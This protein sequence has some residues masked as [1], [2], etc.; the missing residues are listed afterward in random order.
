MNALRSRRPP[1][2]DASPGDEPAA[3]ATPAESLDAA[4]EAALRLLENRRRTRSDL[5]KRLRDKGHAAADVEAA[6]DRLAGVGL[7][8]DVEY[9]RAF[10]A[11][12]WGRRASGWRRL[13]ME[14][15]RR[16]VAPDDIEKARAGFE[17]ERG[18]ADEVAM[19]RRVIAQSERRYAALEPRVRSQRLYALLV[20][21]GFDSEVIA[22]ALRQEIAAAG[23]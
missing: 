21:R 5:A 16:G 23:G 14:L 8:D 19:A 17:E 9:A 2:R 11:E 22:E 12:R 1:R 3:P 4:R 10:L 15:R 18:A 13:E 20:R 6:L 7:V